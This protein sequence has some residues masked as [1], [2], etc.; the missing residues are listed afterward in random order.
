MFGYVLLGGKCCVLVGSEHVTTVPGD[1]IVVGVNVDVKSAL[2]ACPTSVL[3]VMAVRF[4][5]KLP[6][7]LVLP[8]DVSERRRYVGMESHVKA[9]L[10]QFREPPC[11]TV[12]VK[13]TT[14]P[15]HA[16]VLPSCSTL[17]TNVISATMVMNTFI[18]SNHN[19]NTVCNSHMVSIP[20]H[21]LDSMT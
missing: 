8:T 5:W 4:A 13:I 10:A 20:M 12:Q 7:T 14:S 3:L 9:V 2:E 21:N 18:D 6:Q 1:T 15:G 16:A 17:D 11:V 19:E